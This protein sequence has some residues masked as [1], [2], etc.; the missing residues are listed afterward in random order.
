MANTGISQNKILIDTGIV[1][2]LADRGDSWHQ[3]AVAF[4][5][6]YN[7]R[8]IVPATVIPEACYML[9]T[10]LGPKVETSFVESLTRGDFMMESL[11][12]DDLAESLAIMDT[13]ADLNIG[14]V[15]ASLVAIAQRLGIAKILTTDRRHFSVIRPK[16]CA[17]FDLLP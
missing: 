6:A 5:E 1:I 8:I 9:N 14:L 11:T 10:Y 2:A 3:E 16:H 17:S 4:L 7:G 13:Y 12:L 15:E